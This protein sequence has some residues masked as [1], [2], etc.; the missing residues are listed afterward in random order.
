MKSSKS[1][2][3]GD[4]KDGDPFDSDAPKRDPLYAVNRKANQIRSHLALGKRVKP[5]LKKWL[6]D[7][8]RR[9]AKAMAGIADDAD[10]K[11]DNATPAE[12]A[13]REAEASGGSPPVGPSAPP[14]AAAPPPTPFDDA[15]PPPPPPRVNVNRPGA[16]PSVG[17]RM[18]RSGSAGWRG[19]YAMTD[20][21]GGEFADGREAACVYLASLIHGANK[22]MA[23][24]LRE[25]GIEPVIDPDKLASIYVL[26]MDDLLPPAFELTPAMMTVGSTS[27]LTV[28]R[29]I[30]RK[31][32]LDAKGGAPASRLEE[33]KRNSARETVVKSSAAK[34]FT[35]TEPATPPPPPKPAESAPP[36]ASAA[37]ELAKL[38]AERAATESKP[39]ISPPPHHAAPQTESAPGTAKKWDVRAP[40]EGYDPDLPI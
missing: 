8:D 9:G 27:A 7:F 1:G 40:A 26:A 37:D 34:P 3:K 18:G 13:D 17:T 6:A 29:F 35:S 25:V 4:K 30:N 36:P 23:T 5:E 32:I 14:P 21:D 15:P 10:A 22:Q 12:L 38:R 33:I 24:A 16:A 31:K 39:P 28:Q 11:A 19:K 20:A 2:S